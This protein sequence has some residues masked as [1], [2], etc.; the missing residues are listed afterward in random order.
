MAKAKKPLDW[1]KLVA[2]YKTIY[3]NPP[4]KI[5]AGGKEAKYR[6]AA[7]P[8]PQMTLEEMANI[9][10]RDLRHPDGCHLYLWTPNAMLP[11]ALELMYQWGFKYVT[12]ITWLKESPGAGSYFGTMS[13]QCLFGTAAM[14][15]GHTSRPQ[16]PFKTIDGALQRGTTAFYSPR[17]PGFRKPDAMRTMIERVSYG[18]ML[19]LWPKEATK[20][21]DGW[22][23]ENISDIVPLNGPV[24]YK[25]S[26]YA[27][28]KVAFS[29]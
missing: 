18:P 27:H 11:S 1:G 26:A 16:L 2:Q 17:E 23:G 28:R 15:K 24:G 14:Y 12:A 4:W 10:I 29:E 19:E 25:K 20:G 8:Y 6:A 3:A 9:P 13:E 7:L 5:H 21:W 22:N